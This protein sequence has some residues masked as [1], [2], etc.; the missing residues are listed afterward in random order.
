MADHLESPG[1][2]VDFPSFDGLLS[3]Y[4][5][6]VTAVFPSNLKAEDFYLEMAIFGFLVLYFV[7]YFR[8]RSQNQ[9]IVRSW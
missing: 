6:D 3:L 5:F 2:N 9:G 7:N 4:I 1:I 8:G